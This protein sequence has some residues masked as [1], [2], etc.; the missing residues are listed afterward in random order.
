[1]EEVEILKDVSDVLQL[2]GAVI[3]GSDFSFCR[4]FG[5]PLKGPI[6]PDEVLGNRTGSK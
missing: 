3:N 2:P 5:T 6:Y 1:M 4:A